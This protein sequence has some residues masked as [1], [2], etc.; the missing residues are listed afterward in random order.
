M[1]M[2]DVEG[3]HSFVSI[4]NNIAMKGCEEIF[5]VIKSNKGI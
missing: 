4:F 3:D 5:C 1:Q 2:H